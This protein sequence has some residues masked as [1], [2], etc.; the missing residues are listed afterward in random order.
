MTVGQPGVQLRVYGL[1]YSLS[2]WDTPIR[3]YTDRTG[4]NIVGQESVT[5]LSVPESGVVFRGSAHQ[6]AS[7]SADNDKGFQQFFEQPWT[8]QEKVGKFI[9]RFQHPQDPRVW[10]DYAFWQMEIAYKPLPKASWPGTELDIRRDISRVQWGAEI[11]GQGAKN[12][13]CHG[14]DS[15]SCYVPDDPNNKDEDLSPA[16]PNWAIYEID[17]PGVGLTR[18]WT[19]EHRWLK[20]AKYASW[21][22]VKIGG[23]W[24]VISKERPWRMLQHLRYISGQWE[25]DPAIEPIYANDI[26]EGHGTLQGLSGAWNGWWNADYDGQ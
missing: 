15:S 8:A 21:V 20:K 2:L 24:Y 3:A 16:A 4:N 11:P 26:L 1:L 17:L 12:C 23:R 10:Y 22:E 13:R 9:Y 19:E 6:G 14:E 5:V 25:E 7:L 18:G